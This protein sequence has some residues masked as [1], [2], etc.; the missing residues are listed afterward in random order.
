MSSEKTPYPVWQYF[1]YD[2]ETDRSHC[3]VLNCSTKPFEKRHSGNVLVHL[4]CY[5]KE[6]FNVVKAALLK[7]N[8]IKMTRKPPLQKKER[9]TDN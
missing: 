3:L 5:H 4:E 1:R 2:S 7:R 6:Q 9:G 8:K